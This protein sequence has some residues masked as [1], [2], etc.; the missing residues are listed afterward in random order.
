MQSILQNYTVLD[1]ALL[2]YLLIVLPGLQ[3]HA[4]LGAVKSERTRL[5]RYI[6]T[7]LRIFVLLALLATDWWWMGRS[8]AALG[9]GTPVNALGQLGLAADF[10]LVVGCALY[11]WRMSRRDPSKLAKQRVDLEGEKLFPETPVETAWLVAMMLLIGAGW[12]LLYRGYLI[13]ALAPAAGIAGAVIVASLAFGVG[14]GFQSWSRFL[15]SIVSAFAFT[16]AYV[17]TGSLWWLMI[18]HIVLP[19]FGLASY[20]IAARATAA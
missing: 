20:R 12:E 16:L 7:S 13:W 19:L 14:H 15:G 3:L 1:L 2:A 8:A 10:V 18:V 5:S 9:I 17:L 6:V 11:A 4:S